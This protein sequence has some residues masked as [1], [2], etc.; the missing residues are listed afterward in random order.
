MSIF[1]AYYLPVS[2]KS[3]LYPTISPIIS[4]WLILDNYLVKIWAYWRTKAIFQT[5]ITPIISSMKMHKEKENYMIL[6]LLDTIIDQLARPHVYLDPGSGSFLIQLLI[7]GLL[8][9]GIL[10]RNSWSKIINL[11]RRGKKGDIEDSNDE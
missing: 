1:N 7:A 8:G 9:A 5:T 6:N 2:G 10:L 11:F 3:E 4:F